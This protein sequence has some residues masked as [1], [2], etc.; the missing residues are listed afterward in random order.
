MKT[1]RW[2]VG[3][4]VPCLTAVVGGFFGARLAAADPGGRTRR[5]LT[6]AGTL[7]GAGSSA[8]VTF[9]F[10]NGAAQQCAPVVMVMPTAE[11]R[12]P[13]RC[14]WIKLGRCAPTRSSTAAT[15]RS[16]WWSA[17]RPW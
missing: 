10:R 4:V 11:A 14:R 15:C 13:R 6:V 7:T 2:V 16:T 17:G 8:M 9:R 5:A 12:S 3:V 1:R